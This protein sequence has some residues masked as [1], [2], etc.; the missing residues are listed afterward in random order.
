[1]DKRNYFKERL[2]RYGSNSKEQV[3]I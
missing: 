2:G 1:M 3:E